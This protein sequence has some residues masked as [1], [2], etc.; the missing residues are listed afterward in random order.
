M[1]FD[2]TV[3]YTNLSRSFSRRHRKN[4][5]AIPGWSTRATLQQLVSDYWFMCV[6]VDFALIYRISTVLTLL[7]QVCFGLPQFYLISF[8]IAGALSF[9]VLYFFNYRPY[10]TAIFLPMLETVKET[11]DLTVSGQLEK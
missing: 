6:A 10:F 4:Q 8:L 7:V 9:T 2:T 1:A 3:Q 11:Y 5:I